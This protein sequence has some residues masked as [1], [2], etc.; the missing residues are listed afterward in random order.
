ML[1][2]TSSERALWRSVYCLAGLCHPECRGSEEQMR[3]V[4]H[5]A[6]HALQ[7]MGLACAPIL[8]QETLPTMRDLFEHAVDRQE[9]PEPSSLADIAPAQD[10]T[11]CV[12]DSETF[13]Q[14]SWPDGW[15]PCT[16]PCAPC[17]TPCAPVSVAPA[18]VDIAP[19][20]D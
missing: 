19:S 4:L 8:A 12:V 16:T 15:T 18:A 7:E 13:A 9:E 20:T 17:T 2:D 14:L 10:G 1:L 5:E 3:T 6:R 11:I